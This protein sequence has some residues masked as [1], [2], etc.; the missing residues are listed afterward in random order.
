ML[1]AHGTPI[2][3]RRAQRLEQLLLQTLKSNGQ[4]RENLSRVSAVIRFSHTIFALPFALGALLV[5]ANG[6]RQHGF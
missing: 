5:A 1:F 6:R 3:D 2:F 4:T